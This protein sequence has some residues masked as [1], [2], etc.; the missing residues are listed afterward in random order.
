MKNKI[1]KS[2][3]STSQEINENTPLLINSQPRLNENKFLLIN[4]SDEIQN[5]SL[6]QEINNSQNEKNIADFFNETMIEIISM[7]CTI[8]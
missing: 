5:Q 2:Q 3:P 8:S 4:T 6:I 7:K 1:F